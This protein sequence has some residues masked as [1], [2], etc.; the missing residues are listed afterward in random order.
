[1]EPQ[2]TVD[3]YVVWVKKDYQIVGHIEKGR[4]GRFAKTI[5][6]FLRS[7]AL[8]S[9]ICKVTGKAVNLGDGLGQNVPC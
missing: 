5:F 8:S 4:S 7:D 3:Q 1:M 9:C 2:N 6:Y